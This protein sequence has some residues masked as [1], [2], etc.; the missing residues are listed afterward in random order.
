MEI[1][2]LLKHIYQRYLVCHCYPPLCHCYTQVCDDTNQARGFSLIA[3]M[4]G[5][6]RVLVGGCD[7]SPTYHYYCA[8]RVQLLEDFWL[9]Q[10]A[11]IHYLMF[12]SSVNFHICCHVWLPWQ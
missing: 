6:G 10:Q 11:S 12:L 8:Y 2:E 9:V 7:H 5:F 4:A 1:L 3:T